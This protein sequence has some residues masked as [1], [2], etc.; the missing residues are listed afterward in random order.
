MIYYEIKLKKLTFFFNKD[1]Q[2]RKKNKRRGRGKDFVYCLIT[3]MTRN[4]VNNKFFEKIAGE[5]DLIN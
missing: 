5:N 4:P 1:V 2:H 3:R